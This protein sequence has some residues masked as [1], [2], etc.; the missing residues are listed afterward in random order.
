MNQVDLLASKSKFIQKLLRT[1]FVW[2][3]TG[4]TYTT[5]IVATK[6]SYMSPANYVELC[7]QENNELLSRF[8]VDGRTAV[9]EFGCGLGGNLISISSRIVRGVGVDINRGYVRLARALARRSGATNLDFF[10]YDGIHLPQLGRFDLALCLN[11]FE[12]LPR[13]DVVRYVQWMQTQ[14]A[15]QGT[16]IAFFLHQRALETGFANR[17]GKDAYV[18]W[19]LEQ[20]E[21]VMHQSGFRVVDTLKWLEKGHLVIGSR[22]VTSGTS[23]A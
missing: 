16:V 17:L 11:V 20:A 18:F 23:V 2:R 9:V 13:L 14:L 6:G 3:A 10:P 1:A 15:P 22:S 5:A 12:R 7:R 21:E 8:L 19:T 4:S